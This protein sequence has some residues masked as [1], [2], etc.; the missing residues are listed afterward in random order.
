[1]V[2]L[3]KGARRNWHYACAILLTP[4]LADLEGKGKYFT[5]FPLLPNTPMLPRNI[6]RVFTSYYH[7]FTEE[8]KELGSWTYRTY[9][10][11]GLKEGLD[12]THSR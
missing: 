2:L 8:N 12:H 9:I 7:A 6:E 3:L 10:P 4:L 11:Q 1:M 5:V